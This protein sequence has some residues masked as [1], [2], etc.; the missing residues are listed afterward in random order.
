MIKNISLFIIMLII[1]LCSR[2]QTKRALIVAIGNY[3]DKRVNKWKM[4]NSLNDVPLI[5][6]ALIKQNFKE[7]DIIVIIDSMATKAGIINALDQLIDH[8]KAND[9]VFIHFSSHGVQLEDDNGDEVDGL[10]E[11]IVPYGARYSRNDSTFKTLADGYIRDDLFGEKMTLLRNKLGK[12]GDVLVSI[13][14]CHSGSGTRGGIALVRGDNEPMVS[15]NFDSK[16]LMLKDVAGVFKDSNGTRLSADAATYVVIS[17]AR[18]QELNSECLDDQDNPVGSLSYALSKSL[19]LLNEKV[20]YR[21]LFARIEDVMLEKSPGQKPVIEGDGINRNL[22]GGDVQLQLPYFKVNKVSSNSHSVIINGGTLSGVTIGSVISFYPDNTTDTVGKKPLQKGIVD[23]ANSFEAQVKLDMEDTS[24]LK[25]IPW[26]FVSEMQYGKDTLMLSIDSLKVSE[27]GAIKESLK[28]MKQVRFNAKC[29]LYL[30]RS[31]NGKGYSLRYPGSGVLFADNLE[32]EGEFSIKE[33]I[34]RFERYSYLRNLRCKDDSID[35]KV[36]LVFLKS[37]STIDEQKMNERSKFGSSRIIGSTASFTGDVVYLKV[38]NTGL[39]KCYVNIVDISANGV[40]SP[41]IP[42]HLIVD[43]NNKQCCEISKEDCLLDTGTFKI[44]KTYP[45]TF[46]PPFG[47][48]TFKVFISAEELDLESILTEKIDK[49][50]GVFNNIEKL[51]QNSKVNETGKRGGNGKINP[52]ENGT[53]FNV[54]YIIVE[55]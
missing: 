3:P 5:K 53:I 15:K 21:G 23:H 34:K 24:L 35:A 12:K 11:A 49:R 33:A 26:A 6:N 48:E 4:I 17:G 2:A 7:E 47:E 27:A 55:K 44:F 50:G 29:D 46:G 43:E 10:D 36:E 20:T 54:N 40:I 8:S 31:A 45:I 39:K 37:D 30:E 28:L 42:N 32:P 9:I 19:N 38:A 18:A 16:K 41:V 14:A 25:K 1:A 13:D 52:K 51:F 22:F